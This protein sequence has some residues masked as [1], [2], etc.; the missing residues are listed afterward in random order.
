MASINESKGAFSKPVAK[1]LVPKRLL[2]TYI[3]VYEGSPFALDTHVPYL[4]VA[5]N[6]L[7]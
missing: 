3:T 7:K 2:D 5:N 6:L 1:V 4:L